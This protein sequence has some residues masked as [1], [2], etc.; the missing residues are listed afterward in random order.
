MLVVDILVSWGSS[1]VFRVR[2][3]R[4]R[5]RVVVL[6]RGVLHPLLIPHIAHT[7]HDAH[8]CW[9]NI[10]LRYSFSFKLKFTLRMI[11]IFL[12]FNIDTFQN[13]ICCVASL[14]AFLLLSISFL[15][16]SHSKNK[17]ITLPRMRIYTHS[18]TSPRFTPSSV[19]RENGVPNTVDLLRL[20][21]YH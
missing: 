3:R 16:Y 11:F 21:H 7:A 12:Y 18:H 4:V 14:Y 19:V 2:L 15:H 17:K 5:R 10:K 13:I 9:K 1:L 6:Y 8:H 20:A